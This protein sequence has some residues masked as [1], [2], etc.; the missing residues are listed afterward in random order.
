MLF[1]PVCSTGHEAWIQP[2]IY[3][4]VHD[5]TLK[6]DIMV[7]QLFKGHAQIY[8]EEKFAVL[9]ITQ[10]RSRER[11]TG[12]LGDLPAIVHTLDKPGLYTVGYQSTG[13]TISYSNWQKFSS[14]LHAEGLEWVIEEHRSK[15]FPDRD[16]DEV[17]Y[18][19]AKSVVGWQS[20]EGNDI[21]LGMPFEI[22]LLNNPYMTSSD[23]VDVE[24][25]WNSEPY[26]DAQLAVFQKSAEGVVVRTDYLTDKFGKTSVP[27]VAGHQYLLNT[28]YM[29]LRN[30]ETDEALW[31]S[32]WASITFE[33]PQS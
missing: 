31:N 1:L 12:R 10:G 16:F 15:G 24:V 21:I 20:L 33:V 17:F 26:P 13:S 27:I 8:N 5:P 25:M 28:V 30:E 18:R 32:H 7:G 29:E 23:S 19:Y 11:I 14:F 9:D 6:A 4:H 3:Q 22:V 2:L